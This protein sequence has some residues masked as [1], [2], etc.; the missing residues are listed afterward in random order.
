MQLL[1]NISLEMSL[2]VMEEIPHEKCYLF[3][4]SKP[5]SGMAPGMFDLTMAGFGHKQT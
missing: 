2:N 4:D 5:S 1:S 3:G